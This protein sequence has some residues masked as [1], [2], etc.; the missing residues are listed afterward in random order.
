MLVQ[1]TYRQGF[2]WEAYLLAEKHTHEKILF[3]HTDEV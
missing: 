3:G 2:N 1:G